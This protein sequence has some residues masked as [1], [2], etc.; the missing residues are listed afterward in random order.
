MTFFE[1]LKRRNVLRVAAA[2]IVTAWLIIQ[3]AETVLPAFA[4]EH[5]V[6]TVI[7]VLAAGFVPVLMLAWALEW[8]PQGIRLDAGEPDGRDGAAVARAARRF[9]RMVIVI[10]TLALAWFV[11]DKLTPPAPDALFSVAVLPFDN[12]SADAMPDYLAEGLA[13]EV[14]DLLAKLPELV[15]IERSSAFSFK[16]QQTGLPDIGKALGATHLLAGAIAQTSAGVRIRARLFETVSGTTVWSESYTGQLADIFRIQDEIV[17]DTVSALGLRSAGE[18][19]AAR[20]TTP[21]VLQLVLQAKQL[22]NQNMFGEQA[23]VEA[24][25]LLEQA[26]DIDPYYTPALAWS[27]YAD[28]GQMQ[29]GL[30]SF[31]ETNRRW[32][33]ASYRVLAIEPENA[34]IHNSFAWT[35]LHLDRDIRA[36]APSYARALRSAPNDAEILR[37]AARFAVLIGRVEEGYAMIERSTAID[38]LCGF[39][40]YD[41]SKIY[42]WTGRLDRAE[43]LRRR[44]VEEYGQGQFFLGIIKLLQGKPAEAVDIYEELHLVMSALEAGNDGRAHAGLAMAYH[45]L[46]RHD[47]SDA[48]LRLLIDAFGDDNPLDVAKSHAWRGEIDEAFAWLARTD[49]GSHPMHTFIVL[50][51]EF[52]KLHEDPR[53]QEL[54]AALDLSVEGLEAIEFPAELLERFLDDDPGN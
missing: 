20:R 1:E 50:D 13:G 15:V 35:A 21:E 2:Y 24:A 27:I 52:G 19:P 45:E 42:M 46:G 29:A 11:W 34:I 54:R 12:E 30:I 16:G 26:T 38:P 3:V 5:H 36:A 8:T 51:P 32:I 49:I 14:R 25:R 43:A 33:N 7:I 10:L 28:W 44:F 39:C 6:R 37:H 31:D 48:Q 4:L 23:S 22:M 40:L 17:E 18:L 9:D 41:A 47:E 53:W